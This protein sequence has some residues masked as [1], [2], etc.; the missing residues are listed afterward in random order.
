MTPLG[1]G[2]SPDPTR[3]YDGARTARHERPAHRQRFE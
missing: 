2:A 1:S 3:M